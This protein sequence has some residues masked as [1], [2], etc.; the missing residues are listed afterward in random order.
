MAKIRPDIKLTDK[1][2]EKIKLPIS[3]I[4]FKAT[5]SFEEVG[6]FFKSIKNYFKRF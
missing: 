1:I 6:K 2:N 4:G 5:V 3:Y